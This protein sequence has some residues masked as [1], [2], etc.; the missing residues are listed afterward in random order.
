MT[1]KVLIYAK[2]PVK[3]WC[4]PGETV[5]ALRAEFPDVQFVHAASVEEAAAELRDADASLTPHLTAEMVA[6]APRLKWVHSSAAAVEGLLPLADLDARNIH[7]TNSRGIQAIPMAEHVIGGLLVVTHRMAAMLEA[8]R[9]KR[10]SQNEIVDDYPSILYG[11]RMTVVG[12]GTIGMEVARRAQA[13]GM[14]VTGVRRRASEPKPE[15]VERVLPPER[16]DEAL[17]NCD[18]LVLST[19][20]L[21]S[22]QG[23]ISAERIGK[24]DRGAIVANVARGAVIDEQAMIDAL[25]SGQ[26]GG[27]V[28]DV[29]ARE[30]LDPASPLWTLPNVFVSPHVS[31]LRASHWDEI[32]S[33]FAE[34]MWRF[35][36]G[37][38]LRNAIDPQA[39]Y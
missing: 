30:P 28:L 38:T 11:K 25:R 29:F 19:P 15:F 1:L 36:R 9:A 5:A 27:A 20:G 37:E 17:A 10:W 34:N 4:I 16:L 2:W 26:L 24:L 32:R 7:V 31:G 33:L 22:T 39:G 18:V 12:L 6:N 3:A 13:F 35:R 8:Q 14:P 23:M 21:A